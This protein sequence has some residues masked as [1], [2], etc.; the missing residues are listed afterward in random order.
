MKN[1]QNFRS[2]EI[3]A[4]KS[5]AYRFAFSIGNVVLNKRFNYDAR[6]RVGTLAAKYFHELKVD[7]N[8]VKSIRRKRRENKPQSF[9]NWLTNPLVLDY[10]RNSPSSI[11]SDRLCFNRRNHWAKNS[12]DFK[13]LSILKN[14]YSK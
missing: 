14:F 6:T 5:I 3:S 4:A 11:N 9:V 8:A 10:R 7:K 12:T 1:F 2:E 13:I